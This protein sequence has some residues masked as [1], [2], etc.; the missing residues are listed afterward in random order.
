M[1][2]GKGRGKGIG[3]GLGQDGRRDK[4]ALGEGEPPAPSLGA[5]SS[6][7][8]VIKPEIIPIINALFRQNCKLLCT[9]NYPLRIHERGGFEC[10]P[11]YS[12]V[13]RQGV[14]VYIL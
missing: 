1:G 3:D 12:T 14:K 2:E 8:V 4:V 7:K 9:E 5:P 13:P 10:W 11:K 6:P